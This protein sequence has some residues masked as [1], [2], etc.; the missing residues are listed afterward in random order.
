VERE[1]IYNEK[2][3]LLRIAEGDENAFRTIFHRY[4]DNIYTTILSV[5]GMAWMAEEVL[6]DSFLKVWIRSRELPHLDN[7][8]GWLYTLSGRLAINALQDF[9]RKK[10]LLHEHV[11]VD[12]QTPS[13]IDLLENKDSRDMLREAVQ[14]LTERQREAWQLIREQGLK[15]NEAAE[16]MQVSPETVKYHFELALKNVRAFCLAR[17][18]DIPRVVALILLEKYF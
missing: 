15:R 17:M 18:E 10:K 6:Q 4:R 7:F 14:L 2:E 8:G 3:L 12:W 16:K 11:E 5:T 9:K 13:V 1:N